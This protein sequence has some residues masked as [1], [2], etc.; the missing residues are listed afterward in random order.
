MQVLILLIGLGILVT[1]LKVLISKFSQ[2]TD[3]QQ[4]V[5]QTKKDEPKKIENR[6]PLKLAVDGTEA[7]ETT[8]AAAGAGP[9]LPAG[10]PTVPGVQGAGS[11]PQ[12]GGVQASSSQQA[13]QPIAVRSTSSGA[14][15]QAGNDKSAAT[16]TPETRRMS[17]GMKYGGSGETLALRAM[18]S[19]GDSLLGGTNGAQNGS[20]NNGLGP[21]LNSTKT[22]MSTARLLPD[23]DFYLAKGTVIDCTAQEA[24]DTTQPG[25]LNC[26]GSTDVYSK[27]Q[28]VVLLERGTVYTVEYQKGLVQGQ[29]KIFLL[30]SSAVRPATSKSI[31]TRQ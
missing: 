14:Q 26:I 7:G 15:Q 16:D 18:D 5:V 27:S 10:N 30:A 19:T 28:R 20:G 25:M 11:A 4:P 23:P 13:A 21:L 31:W 29:N 1:S 2:K 24:I 17:K 22:A 12:G 3:E 9:A 8:G 6:A